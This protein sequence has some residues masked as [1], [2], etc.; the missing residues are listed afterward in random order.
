MVYPDSFTAGGGTAG[1]RVRQEPS[2]RE[3]LTVQQ[4][5]AA[6]SKYIFRKDSDYEQYTEWKMDQHR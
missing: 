5:P 1:L 2:A 3:K 4:A 6:R